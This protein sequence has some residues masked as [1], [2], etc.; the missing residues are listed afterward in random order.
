MSNIDLGKMGLKFYI[1]SKKNPVGKIPYGVAKEGAGENRIPFTHYA[2]SLPTYLVFLDL[3]QNSKLPKA[4]VL[5]L[6]SGTGR[7]ISYVKETLDREKWIFYGIDYS[8][9]CINYAKTQYKKQ[10]VKFV[11]HDGRELPYPDNSFDYL[12][13]SHVMEHIKEE[14]QPLYLSEMARVLKPRGIAVVGEPNRKYCQ[15][16]FCLN[17]KEEERYRLVL[18]HE[19]EH[20]AKD[21][22]WLYGKEKRFKSYTIWQTMNAIC[23]ELFA[24]STRRIKPANDGWQKV[25]SEIYS[26]VRRNHFVQDILAKVGTELLIRKMKTSYEELLKATKLMQYDKPDNG[27]NFIVIAKK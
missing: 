9:A 18:P 13:S 14:D 23:R 22:R 3:L 19:H 26:V 25:I 15:D 24:E 6:G 12:V 27:D 7:N 10:K 2:N 21:L 20:Y 4:D 17:P 11:Q 5:D 8:V 16:L 1:W